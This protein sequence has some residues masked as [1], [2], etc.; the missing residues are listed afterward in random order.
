MLTFT[1]TRLEADEEEEVDLPLAFP[2]AFPP[3][4]LPPP[5]AAAA[6]VAATFFKLTPDEKSE[7]DAPDNEVKSATED[8]CTIDLKISAP[9]TPPSLPP[10][11]NW[12]VFSAS[13]RA[14]RGKQ[15]RP[16]R[17]GR[18]A[19]QTI[20]PSLPPPPTE[21]SLIECSNCLTS[22]CSCCCIFKACCRP[23]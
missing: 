2:P 3:A 14:G 22:C 17:E 8:L 9:P 7:T 11:L 23:R 19:V 21:A 1:S 4:F 18:G 16:G 15:D 12:A 20:P 13:F 6:A 10:S 5:P